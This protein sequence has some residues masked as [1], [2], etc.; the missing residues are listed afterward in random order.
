M[1]STRAAWIAMLSSAAILSITMG[2]RQSVGLFVSPIDAS[3]GLRIVSI[4]FALAVGQFVWGLAQPIF[5]AFADHQGPRGAL[6]AGALLL[7]GGLALTPLV[8]LPI[9]EKKAGL[10][11]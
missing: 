11:I 3:T 7:A 4:S 6:V 5:G 9:R 1:N 2:A 10:G 8:N